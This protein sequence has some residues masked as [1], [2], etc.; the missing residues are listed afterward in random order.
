MRGYLLI[1][2][3][4]VL[5][6]L[7][8]A[9]LTVALAGSDENG[10][11]D[12]PGEK[13]VDNKVPVTPAVSPGQGETEEK[14]AE[15]RE[16]DSLAAGDATPPP[17][18]IADPAE[19][20]PA[21]ST[22][23]PEIPTLSDFTGETVDTADAETEEPSLNATE[24]SE[25]TD[26]ET[27]AAFDDPDDEID[28]DLA[29][30]DEDAEEET[31][32]EPTLERY[33]PPRPGATMAKAHYSHDRPLV[34]SGHNLVNP[35]SSYTP[36]GENETGIAPVAAVPS[37]GL[38]VRGIGVILD[39]TPE[40]VA[41]TRSGVEI[42]NLD[43]LLDS[44]MRLGGRHP[45]AVFEG[46]TFTVTVTVEARNVTITEDDPAYVVLVP[47][48]DETGVYEITR[49]RE[50]RSL[51]DGERGVWE[52]SVATRTGR[53]TLENLTL[54][55]E[56]L[57]TNLTSNPDLFA[58]HAYAL[59]GGQEVP[60]AGVSD[61]V[62][63]I[64]PD[65]DAETAEASSLPGLYAVLGVENSTLRPSET[66]MGAWARGVD[67]ETIAAAA[68]GHLEALRGLGK[69]DV[70][71]FYAAEGGAGADERSASSPSILDLIVGF[72]QGLLG[73]APSS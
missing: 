4:L 1:V 18:E 27:D 52:F 31:N 61:P 2:G 37:D 23:S 47:P 29:A 40:D 73:G 20:V 39:R 28:D 57:V 60:S 48:P 68:V 54:A 33:A 67:H 22:S 32:P 9:L 69:E 49:T 21:T 64:R 8:T 25:S 45:R 50:V 41:L 16:P 35:S 66:M 15:E 24:I 17:E 34:Q 14:T 63:A 11:V 58:F 6:I 38:F 46:E 44:A 3:A 12:L 53:L 65:A 42:A 10:T 56:R 55:E 62:I 30:D 19:T 5:C 51:G 26:T 13:P 72:F 43:W 59:A 7:M 36:T 71:A 70:A